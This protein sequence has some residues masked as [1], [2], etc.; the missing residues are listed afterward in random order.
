MNTPLISSPHFYAWESFWGMLMPDGDKVM[1]STIYAWENL[2][3]EGR[4]RYTNN[5]MGR[6][7]NDG[8][9]YGFV[10]SGEAR[11]HSGA[12]TWCLSAGQ[13]FTSKMG[14]TVELEQRKSVVVVAQR[15]K[16][17][18]FDRAGGPIEPL[19]RLRYIDLC[20]DT[21]LAGPMKKGEPCLNHLHFPKGIDQTQHTHPSSRIGIVV[22]GRG[23]CITPLGETALVPGLVFYIPKDGLH[24]FKTTDQEM[25]VIAYHPDSD[26]GPTDEEHPMVNRTL[27]DGHK[28]DNTVGI[29][30]RA[31]VVSNNL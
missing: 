27:V 31:E 19:G 29:H 30:T 7:S 21:L 20:S 17:Y 14:V 2:S 6:T 24:K 13:Y 26:F 15:T 5:E 10:Q 1:P 25:D 22:R 3:D 18:G 8:G 12:L 4:A 28:I 11:I 23:A 16:Y 9:C